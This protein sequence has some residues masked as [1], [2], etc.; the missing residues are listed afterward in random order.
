MTFY[1]NDRK[2]VEVD[3]WSKSEYDSTKKWS[4]FDFLAEL[5]DMLGGVEPE[6]MFYHYEGKLCSAGF[7]ELCE[8][9]ERSGFQY[10][11]SSDVRILACEENE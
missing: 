2:F 9:D 11:V 4:A 6:H 1:A 5:D 10:R 8:D 7:C 3:R